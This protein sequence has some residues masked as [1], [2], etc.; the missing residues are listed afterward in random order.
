MGAEQSLL[1]A[2]CSGDSAQRRAAG[3]KEV[4]V[5]PMIKER[6]ERKEMELDEQDELPAAIGGKVRNQSRDKFL[7]R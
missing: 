2:C 7:V 4:T 5:E 3:G 6:V 1:T